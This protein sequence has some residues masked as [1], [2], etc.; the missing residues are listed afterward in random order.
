[1][2]EG[3][4]LL[5]GCDHYPP[6]PAE[7]IADAEL[8]ERSRR[9]DAEAFGLL[10]ER[11][12]QLVFGVA[13]ARCRDRALAE[14]VAQDAFVAAWRDLDRLRDVD[15]VGSWVAGIARNLAA[16]AVRVQ[17]RRR[18]DPPEL[19]SSPDVP[20]PEDEAVERED[21]ELLRHALGDIPQAHRES[22]VLHYMEG[23]SVAD[24]AA[25]LGIR[26]DLVK[27]RLSRGRR[28][29]RD[30]V[31]TRVEAALTR[32]RL[33]P[34][35]SAGVVAALLTVGARE[36]A[37]AGVTG[38]AIAF[39]S[40]KKL[41]L[42]ALALFLLAGGAL[43]FGTRTNAQIAGAA[44]PH[45]GSPASSEDPAS[46]ASRR[47]A[48]RM[49]TTPAQLSGRVTRKA[50][51]GGIA[52]AVVSL[53][54]DQM[55]SMF[56][57]S[58]EHAVVVVADSN[59]AWIAPQVAPGRYF[60]AASSVGFS[61]AVREP[62]SVRPGERR[63]AVDLA[64][65]TGGTQVSGTVTDVG[66]GP[67][68]GA[69]VTLKLD[70]SLLGE[71]GELVALTKPDGSYRITLRAG[72]YKAIASHDDYTKASRDLE[73]TDEPAVI[74]FV[75][76]PGGVIRGRVVTRDRGEPLAGAM[77]R[78][79]SG[80]VT[81][82]AHG[83]FTLRGLSSGAIEITAQGMGY[84]STSPTV[85]KL[86]IGEQVED[87]RVAIDRAFSIKGR[88]VRKGK[89]SEGLPGV[90]LTA[91]NL[92]RDRAIAPAP[93]GVDGEFEI[94]GVRPGRYFLAAFA[95]GM[96]LEIGQP[97]EVI[98]RDVDGVIVEMSAG[99]TVSGRVDGAAIAAIGVTPESATLGNMFDVMKAAAVHGAS[100]PGGAFV[101][102]NVPHGNFTLTARTRDGRVGTLAITVRDVDQANLVVK[103][104]TRASIAGRVID[105]N[106]APVGGLR[107]SVPA[108]DGVRLTDTSARTSADGS[109]R[110]AGLDPG[111]LVVRVSDDNGPLKWAGAQRD[112]P[113]DGVT[114][115]VARGAAL[116]DVTLT[117]EARDGWIRGVVLGP[118]LQPA[119]DTWVRTQ[120]ETPIALGAGVLGDRT[121][122]ISYAPVLTNAEGKFVIERLRRG[123]YALVAEGPRASSR[124][125]KA[126]VK[127]GDTVK[128]VL[129]PLGTLS[130][131]VSANGRP[132]AA[133]ELSCDGPS[134]IKRSITAA[135]GNGGYTIDNVA[136]GAYSCSVNADE[137]SAIVKLEV[138]AGPIKL[139]FMLAG[140][141]TVT[142][143]AVNVLTGKPVPGLSLLA[144]LP[145]KEGVYTFDTFD[146]L[147][148][149]GPRTDS[150]GRFVIERTPAGKGSVMVTSKDGLVGM[151]AY[152]VAERGRVDL[153][154]VEVIAPPTGEP[155]TLGMTTTTAPQDLL[156]VT[157]V[158]PDGPAARGGVAVG[159]RVVAIDGREPRS[160]VSNMR[161][162]V[163]SSGMLS[164]GQLVELTIERGGVRS[165]ISLTAVPWH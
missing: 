47:A 147:G 15:R 29:L 98:D 54:R 130:G 161:G 43:W 70:E 114:F 75:V 103:L 158:T 115:E 89:P 134:S 162:L 23:R 122:T 85:V 19:A 27:Q 118:D 32:T 21:R 2:S 62:V 53:A 132:V 11:H 38:K 100:D 123:S 163:V 116:T 24:I 120:A 20:S 50:D 61:A 81:A 82:D 146:T 99:S 60:M 18:V 16:N 110:V 12:Q 41:A 37:A 52:G 97:V 65:E 149:L 58:D 106:G 160:F 92:S 66:G 102:H 48:G 78:T 91:G 59:G 96:M 113:I 119:P 46:L 76:T 8:V 6:M 88:V 165:Q 31:A 56:D 148:D 80:G 36:A 107:V 131:R 14:D 28:A 71:Q 39:M 10:V 34:A 111:K 159:D 139:D 151:H 155:G 117:V 143:I 17:L 64:L 51:G 90:A 84:A 7:V 135:D 137:G 67:I 129:S 152:Q 83:R 9:R 140:W 63:G 55:S 101:L 136:P 133:Y 35:F 1:T 108:I 13:L 86:G 105:G 164:S 126:A 144:A 112:K 127:T 40:A 57:D 93:T 42:A 87:V 74:D 138:P 3:C 156:V 25:A 109:F 77:V 69:R 124:T 141:G 145:V 79:R 44:S 5:L 104:E 157:S 73:L 94:V 150:N 128:L 142:G 153:G 45:A 49:A 154:R 95:E 33:R 30:G 72:T 125:V 121:M 26:E 22:L 68:D 4:H